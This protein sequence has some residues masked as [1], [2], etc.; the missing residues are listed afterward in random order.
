MA[1]IVECKG[2]ESGPHFFVPSRK[3]PCYIGG[4][5]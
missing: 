2:I 5:R 1:P 3:V 4:S